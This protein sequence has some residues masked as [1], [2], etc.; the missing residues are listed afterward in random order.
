MKLYPINKF[1]VVE[2]VEEKTQS[3]V[4]LPEGFVSKSET[5]LYRTVTVS[6]GSDVP[7]GCL[8]VVLS[9]MVSKITYDGS[10]Y[11]TVPESAIIGYFAGI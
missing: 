1:V 7:E 3:S 2:P 6:K 5:K 8:A 10:T 4:L 11:L 9:N